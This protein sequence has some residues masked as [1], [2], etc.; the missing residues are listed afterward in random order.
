[1][2]G[3]DPK[4]MEMYEEHDRDYDP[5]ELFGTTEEWIALVRHA[6]CA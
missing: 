6:V 4:L 3:P 1:M 2:W 5:A